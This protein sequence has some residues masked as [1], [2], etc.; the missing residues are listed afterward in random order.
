MEYHYISAEEFVEAFKSFR[1]GVAIEHELAIPFQKSRSHPAALTKTKYGATKKELMKACLARDVTLM[2]R[3]A[4]L[5]IFKIIQVSSEI[6]FL[7]FFNLH[8]KFQSVT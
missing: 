3:S 2:K 6:S 5:H 4:S 1:I 8:L 7:L